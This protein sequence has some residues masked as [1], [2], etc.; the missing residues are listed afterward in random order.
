MKK[1]IG[2]DFG[3]CFSSAA[4]YD[5]KAV[6]AVNTSTGTGYYGDSF[7]MP[8]AVF[9][10]EDG[11]VLVGQLADLKRQSNPEAF[12]KEF[13][14]DLGQQVPYY[15]R[16]KKYSPEDLCTEIFK[17]IKRSI[18][19]YLGES[20]DNAVIT[21]PADFGTYK[22]ELIKNAAEK[23]GFIKSKLVDEPSAAAIYYDS[24]GKLKDNDI[25]LVYDLGGG[26]FD[27]SILKKVEGKFTMLT[28]P[29]GLPHCGGIDFTRSIYGDILKQFDK[30]LSPIINNSDD[31]DAINTSKL[32]R[33]FLEEESIKIKHALSSTEECEA[34]IAAGAKYL[35]YKLTREKF[36]NMISDKVM[37]SCKLIDKIVENAGISKK[38]ITKVLLIGGSCRM[39][40]IQKK[41]AEYTGCGVYMDSSPELAVA[42]GA[43]IEASR[44][45]EELLTRL[46]YEKN[47]YNAIKGIQNM[48]KEG[49]DLYSQ[50]NIKSSQAFKGSEAKVLT[51]D[52]E[53]TVTIKPGTSN[54]ELIKIEGQGFTDPNTIKKR[55]N[56]FA[57]VSI[58]KEESKVFLVDKN[59]GSYKSLTEAVNAASNGDKIIAYPGEYDYEAIDVINMD[60]EIE[61]YGSPENVIINTNGSCTFFIESGKV[62]LKNLTVKCT[63]DDETDFVLYIVG[64]EITAENCIF[65]SGS[66]KSGGVYADTD[67]AKCKLNGCTIVKNLKGVA[68]EDGAACEIN[69]CKISDNSSTGVICIDSNLIMYECTINNNG[70][71]SIGFGVSLSGKTTCTMKK[72]SIQSN[73]YSGIIAYNTASLNL[74]DCEVKG[75]IQDGIYIYE[76]GTGIISECKVYENKFHGIEI[77]NSSAKVFKCNSYSNEKSGIM[78]DN[79]TTSIIDGCNFNENILNGITVI[80]KG[81]SN[82][83]NCRAYE[84][85]NCGIYLVQGG[86]VNIENSEINSNEHTGVYLDGKSS[87]KIN[88]CLV[89]DNLIGICLELGSGKFKNS[90]I[91]SNTLN[92]SGENFFKCLENSTVEGVAF[93]GVRKLGINKGGDALEA[94]KA[95]GSKVFGDRF[96]TKHEIPSN[97]IV[98][99]KAS[100][101]KLLNYSEEIIFMYDNSLLGNGK[102]GFV[103]T[104]KAFYFKPDGMDA[105]AS[106]KFADIKD[107]YVN[108]KGNFQV[109]FYD[110]S[111]RSKTI[112]RAM[113]GNRL[114]NKKM[115]V[116]FIYKLIHEVLSD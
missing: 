41:V 84:N 59:G 64:G 48:K 30:E 26:T 46:E 38:D 89:H 98:N 67:Q 111:D 62:K 20:V 104:D 72:C 61:G 81:N 87:A 7:S 108:I 73:N 39:P 9:I 110:P 43:A 94:Y 13:K 102:T 82:I 18:E 3:T 15:I 68:I 78:L 47:R 37:Q 105:P 95:F 45:D 60:I 101:V 1:Y 107:V 99:A 74:N 103:I 31:D 80:N 100:Y 22:K 42:L 79:S 21:H 115:L 54:G 77:E 70:N 71:A 91:Y 17:H 76:N 53:S 65:T 106:A 5:G 114:P 16:D 10:E 69:N 96:Y 12:K 28:K 44:G 52:G 6:Q 55:G 27:L 56:H 57:A 23:S 66:E 51:L 14:R 63:S 58:Q 93:N 35:R 113:V 109:I 116:Y 49:L 34:T 85:E 2:I 90:K 29:L 112:E 4:V 33:V 97:K 24:K 40:Y 86:K 25:L 8:T 92:H 11:S 36:N 75:N 88:N 83:S 50:L 32:I 19:T